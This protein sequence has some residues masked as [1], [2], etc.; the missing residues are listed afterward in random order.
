MEHFL[1]DDELLKE[2][3]EKFYYV[4][5]DHTGRK[6]LFFENSGG[7]LRL[8]AAVEAKAKMEEIPDC[9]ERT[10]NI[11]EF[12][13]A[14]KKKA[15]TDLREVIFGSKSGSIV[16]ELTASQV[17]FRIARAIIENVPGTNVITTSVEHPSAHDA[18]ETFAKK[19]GKEF[20]VAMGNPKTGGVDTKEILRHVDENTCLLSI[21]SASNVSGYIFDIAEIVREAR[22]IK[23]DLFII[24]DGVQHLPHS[25]F[26]A[27]ELGVDAVNF[28]PYK[29]FGI[30]GCGYGW[31]SDR[32]ARLPHDKLLGKVPEEWELGTFPHPNFAAISAVVDY[33]CWVGSHFTDSKDRR[34]LYVAG[35]DKIHA[36]EH[37][38]W[39]RMMDGSDKVPGLRKQP[40]VDVFLDSS[41]ETD[42]DFI[43]AI[44]IKG[45][46]MAGAVK[47]YYARG[48]TVFE[49]VNT[50]LYSKR[51]IESLGLTGCI[52]VSPLHCHTVDEI[53]EFLR[54]TQD[55]V[56]SQRTP[57]R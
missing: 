17:M 12:L 8:K 9:P 47:E 55:I 7:A 52:R 23:P 48:V 49:R 34:E 53:D 39:I 31:V 41:N 30:R 18:A 20:R 25:S 28:A 21:M 26:N 24:T 11:A 57:A 5:R 27:D 40:G 14:T 42:R 44:G 37:S 4:E 50:S 33:V 38:L 35:M 10:N 32:V 22:K 3:R 6:R 36:H 1:F 51:I 29:A 13:Q 56:A 15:L 54:I 45:M 2:I 46:D 16:C 43:A 19:T